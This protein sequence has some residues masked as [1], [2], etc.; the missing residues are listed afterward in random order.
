ML[1]RLI[2]GEVAKVQ[3]GRGGRSLAFRLTLE[4][5]TQGYFKPEQS[6]SGAL[7]FAEVAAYHLDRALGLRRVPPVVTRRLPWS[8]LRSAAARNPHRD[9]IVIDAEGY[10]RGAFIWW[11]PRKLARLN[12][13]PEW[14]RW[15]RIRPWGYWHVTPYQR[16]RLYVE[17]LRRRN[18]GILPHKP[19]RRAPEQPDPPERAAE[20]SDM[21]VFDY[22]TLNIDR[23]GG[24]N[25]NVL[26]YGPEGPLIFLDNAAGFAKGRQQNG[27][28][29]DRL[30]VVQR[31]RA[32]TIERV[33]S[34]DLADLKERLERE[35]HGPLLDQHRWQGLLQRRTALLEHVAELEEAHGSAAVLAWP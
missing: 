13:P 25:V 16:P 11:L 31:F 20:L 18:R 32:Q 29:E 8:L 34:L 22:L 33:R 27:L 19:R 3:P 4:D 24:N 2:Q 14:E 5:G 12:T 30:Q 17:A 21:A 28:M 23:W 9:E 7:W 10:V 6:F 26:T 35:A 1:D 15:L